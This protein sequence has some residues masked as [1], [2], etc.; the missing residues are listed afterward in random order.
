MREFSLIF[1]RE[2]CILDNYLLYFYVMIQF[3]YLNIKEQS[4]NRIQKSSI[5]SF[6]CSGVETY[7]EGH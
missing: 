1:Q 5:T 3:L 4:L 2:A 6:P 7:K